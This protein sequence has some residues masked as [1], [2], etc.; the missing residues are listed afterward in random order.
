MC[1]EPE[2][3]AIVTI[4]EIV[5][6]DEIKD[7]APEVKTFYASFLDREV[8]GR[9]RLRSGQFIMC[10]V[11]GAGEFAHVPSIWQHD[12]IGRL[13]QEM[14]RTADR[15]QAARERAEQYT[16]ERAGNELCERLGA[17]ARGG[18]AR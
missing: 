3:A 5:N 2:S 8:A 18:Q 10:T 14:N 13:A 17:I 7:E 12:E 16:W 1:R 6:I 15:L 4:P 9:F 11:F